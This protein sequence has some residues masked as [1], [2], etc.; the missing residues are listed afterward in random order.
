[1]GEL[2]IAV[3]IDAIDEV[4]GLGQPSEGVEGMSPQKQGLGVAGQGFEEAIGCREHRSGIPTVGR[5]LGSGQIDQG[6]VR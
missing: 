5:D 2:R 4:D 1:M 3:R 6:V